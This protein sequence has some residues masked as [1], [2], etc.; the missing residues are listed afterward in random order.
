LADARPD[1]PDARLALAATLTNLGNLD[2]ATDHPAEAEESYLRAVSLQE[3]LAARQPAAASDLAATRNNLGNLY[4]RQDKLEQAGQAYRQALALRERLIAEQPE[5]TTHQAELAQLHNNL[6][7]LY[8]RTG[9]AA[10]RRAALDRSRRLYED[11]VRRYPAVTVYAVG[12][13]RCYRNHMDPPGEEVDPDQSLAWAERAVGTLTAVLKKEPR[14]ASALALLRDLGRE[15]T[16]LYLRLGR[17]AEALAAC[18]AEQG[19]LTGAA[20]EELRPRRELILT[21]LLARAWR[22]AR[23]GELTAALAACELAERQAE[24]PA[25]ARVTLARALAL[26]AAAVAEDPGRPAGDRAREAEALAARAVRQLRRAHEA[27][28]RGDAWPGD[29]DFAALRSRPDFAEVCR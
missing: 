6:A 25:A 27:G 12:L 4:L 15:R 18:D 13:G 10:E 2:A 17:F 9:A 16:E 8:R 21:Q 3:P 28:V 5:V 11:L 7:A 26:A 23:A 22:Q 20:A 24:V 29:P 19:V 14:Q 1:D